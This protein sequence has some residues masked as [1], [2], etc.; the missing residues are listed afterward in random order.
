[1]SVSESIKRVP[2]SRKPQE[3]SVDE[4]QA[5]L[6]KQFATDQKFKIQNIGDHPLYSDFE[7]SNPET[8]MTYKVSIRDNLS[9]YNYCSCPDFK[10]NTLGTCKHVEYVLFKLL[11]YKKYQKYFTQLR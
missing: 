6:R 11:R 3:M 5:E 2:Y 4:W 9:S 1:M 10:V 8:G 7:V